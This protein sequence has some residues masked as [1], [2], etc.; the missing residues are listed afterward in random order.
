MMSDVPTG[1]AMEPSPLE[2]DPVIEA[3]KR[4]VDRSLFDSTLALTVEERLRDLM[5]LQ[6]LADELRR[7]GRKAF[8]DRP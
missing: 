2:P 1:T 6:R 7:A 3:C 8:D 5:S 4:D